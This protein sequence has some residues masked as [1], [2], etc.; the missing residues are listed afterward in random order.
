MGA[1]AILYDADCPAI[2]NRA[3]LDSLPP[4]L[5]QTPGEAETL[6][7]RILSQVARTQL[8]VGVHYFAD[9]TT[10]TF[11]FR[12]RGGS[13]IL[14]GQV[15]TKMPAP[16]GSSTGR[17]PDNFGAVAWLKVTA[18]PNGGSVGYKEV[19]RLVTAGGV[20]PATCDGRDDVFTIPYAAEY[21][22]YN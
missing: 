16:S 20:A 13:G 1:L 2:Q 22:F 12:Q 7:V 11:D 18:K 10:P 3:L 17:S 9:L 8:V 15:N 19:F 4:V 6:G 5:V 14:V 21:W